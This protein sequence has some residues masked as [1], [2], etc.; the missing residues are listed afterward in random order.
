MVDVL[1]YISPTWASVTPE[2]E[3]VVAVVLVPVMP[4]PEYH[5]ALE[6]ASPVAPVKA[7]WKV[8][9][10]WMI[11]LPFSRDTGMSTVPPWVTAVVTDIVTV[12]CVGSVST[13]VVTPE[14]A[15]ICELSTEAATWLA[16]HIATTVVVV[17]PALAAEMLP[18][19]VKESLV[20]ITE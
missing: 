3:K 17:L 8:K 12:G 15:M 5:W 19:K 10:L 1:R 9:Y 2:P 16:P 6:P 7:I 20:R 4:V 11:I 13:E 18:G 14:G